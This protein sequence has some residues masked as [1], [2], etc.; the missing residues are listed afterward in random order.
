MAEQTILFETEISSNQGSREKFDVI[1]H[2]IQYRDRPV[3]YV[4]NVY[5][6]LECIKVSFYTSKDEIAIGHA[7]FCYQVRKFG[8]K[9]DQYTKLILTRSRL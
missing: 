9:T 7:H 8:S 2:L 5:C 3:I 4:T 6:G 1:S